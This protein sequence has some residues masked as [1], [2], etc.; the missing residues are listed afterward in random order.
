MKAL[1]IV[2]VVSAPRSPWQNPF[3]ERVVGTLRREL[4][5]HVIVLNERH[6]VRL[7]RDFQN[8]YYNPWRTHLGLNKDSPVQ[9]PEAG[10]RI[11]SIRILGGLHHRYERR[12]A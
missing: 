8:N 10:S 12:A 11:V 7:L 2:E 1:G 6:A 9:P 3:A 4:L 5:D